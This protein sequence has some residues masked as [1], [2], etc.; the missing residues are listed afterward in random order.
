[1]HWERSLM[2]PGACLL[3][4]CIIMENVLSLSVARIL[5]INS[6]KDLEPKSYGSILLFLGHSR[7]S[8][9]P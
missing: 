2:N 8:D 4:K 3:S 5:I 9:L 1:M 7:I 6:M